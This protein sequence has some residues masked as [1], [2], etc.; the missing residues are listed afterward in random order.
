M[1][2][3]GCPF[4]GARV[5]AMQNEACVKPAS[6]LFRGMH[7]VYTRLSGSQ[8]APVD[9]LHVRLESLVLLRLCLPIATLLLVITLFFFWL[10]PVLLLNVSSKPIEVLMQRWLLCMFSLA[11][12]RASHG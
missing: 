10:L 8:A 7:R 6:L 9:E 5:D 1:A 12:Y 11:R 2:Q 3:K 4:V